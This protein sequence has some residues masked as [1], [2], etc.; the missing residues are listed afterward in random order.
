MND[1]DNELFEQGTG[2][3][4]LD[5]YKALVG[6]SSLHD[7]WMEDTVR[8]PFHIDNISI[9]DGTMR[10]G[11]LSYA[12]AYNMQDMAVD[13]VAQFGLSVYYSG[14]HTTIQYTVPTHYNTVYSER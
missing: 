12:Q 4:S 7:V 14:Q 13:V 10:M 3:K 11:R 1:N 6:S 5:R 2:W 8:N 9:C